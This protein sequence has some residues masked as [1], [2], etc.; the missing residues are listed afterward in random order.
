MIFVIFN[1]C[2][3]HD[4]IIENEIDKELFKVEKKKNQQEVEICHYNAD[5]DSWETISVN[6]NALKA[7][8]KHGDYKGNCG[9]FESMFLRNQTLVRSNGK[10]ETTRP[11]PDKGIGLLD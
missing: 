8:L 7:H 10:V 6:E 11:E 3:R 9:F 1:S 4:F 5:R 2:I